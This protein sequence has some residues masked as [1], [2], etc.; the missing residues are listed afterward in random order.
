MLDATLTNIEF[1]DDFVNQRSDWLQAARPPEPDLAVDGLC[2][3][4]IARLLAVI[5]LA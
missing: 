2:Q 1:T 4:L 3:S 5:G